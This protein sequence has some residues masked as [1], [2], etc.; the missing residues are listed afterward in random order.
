MGLFG[1][2]KVA[3]ADLSVLKTDI[4]SHFI[5]G[6]DDGAK[7]MGNSLELLRGMQE[8]GY[9]KVIT[10]PHIMGDSYRNT[11]QIILS[12]LEKVREAIAKEG[13]NIKI[14]AAAEYYLDYSFEEKLK[15]KDILH[16][17]GDKKYLLWEMAFV[18]PPDNMNQFVFDMLLQ[19]YKPVLAHVERY[20]FWQRDYEKYEELVDRGI[21]LQMNINSLTGHY[22]EATKKVAHWLI[23]KDM[24]NFVGS[25]CHHVGHQELM[26]K[27]LKEKYMHKLLASSKLLNAT[28]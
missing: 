6:I 4:H 10:T 9:Q 8:F 16:F 2:G 28:L 18:N 1:F 26:R 12:G 27:A 24:I 20:G 13:L 22:S 5:P 23:D 11:P 7:D 15:N 3:A 14:E 17:G 25:D 21:L 19:G